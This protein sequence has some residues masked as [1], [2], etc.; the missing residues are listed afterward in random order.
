MAE[1]IKGFTSV[2]EYFSFRCEQERNYILQL[3][4]IKFIHPH[5][6]D[7][8]VAKTKE[9]QQEQLMQLRKEG[10][11]LQG[12]IVKRKP[13]FF[14]AMK[15]FDQLNNLELN[16]RIEFQKFI[17]E[18]V[19]GNMI[20]LNHTEYK[21]FSQLVKNSLHEHHKKAKKARQYEESARL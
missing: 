12:E 9:E 8:E 3:K 4:K 11:T 14:N 1:S 7:Q 18:Q 19:L 15:Q 13:L 16:N 6:T 5:Y 10:R 21:E 20:A 2:F 17:Q